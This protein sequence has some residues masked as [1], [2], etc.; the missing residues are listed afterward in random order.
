M[1][2]ACL[3]KTAIVT[4]LV[5]LILFALLFDSGCAKKE[6]KPGYEL[7]TVKSSALNLEPHAQPRFLR[8]Q[9]DAKARKAQIQI[10]SKQ[11]DVILPTDPSTRECYLIPKDNPDN[12]PRWWGADQLDAT[13]LVDGK[14]YRLSISSDNERILV[15][16]Y[17]GDLG[18]FRIGKGDRDIEK[19]EVNGSLRSEDT[20]VMIGSSLENE[21]PQPTQ[22]I[23][24]PVGDY[25]PALLY[26]NM[27]NLRIM[28]S[29]N[30][31]TNAKGQS[32][33]DPDR[34]KI[35][36]FTIR[37]DKPFTLDFSK[38]PMV[39]FESPKDDHPLK[40]GEELN[41]VALLIDPGLDIMIRRLNDT[42]VKETKE[43]TDAQ[44][45]TNSYEQDKSLDPTVTIARF[46]G[47]VVAEGTMPFG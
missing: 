3:L 14:Y 7:K 12:P 18:T 37:K 45:Q 41:V 29:D 27:D 1:K 6:P 32:R 30:Y 8:R 26:I 39:I 19:I 4:L 23:T 28:V 22:S 21:W 11:F 44:G 24:V 9:L 43:Y 38:K 13:H 33:N 35:Y 15:N 2:T 36:G 16:P 17:S 5:P 10:A 42:S 25:L 46:D 31:H 34:E 40:L 20:S 47:E